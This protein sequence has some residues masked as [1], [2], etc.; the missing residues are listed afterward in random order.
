MPDPTPTPLR[1]AH[2]PNLAELLRRLGVSLVVTT[3]QAGKLVIVRADGDRVNTHFRTLPKPMGVAAD[4][5][6]LAVGTACEVREYQDHPAAA[7]EL[8]PQ[9]SHD[10]CYLPRVAHTTGDILVHEMTWA[11]GELWF[12]NTRFSCLCTRSDRHSFTPRWKPS[13]VSAL[14]PEDRCHLNGVGVRDDRVRYATAL[15]ETDAPAGWRANKR[16]GGVLIDV[17]RDEILL[18]GLSMPHSPR[19]R[20]GRL[21]LLESGRGGIGFVNDAGRYEPVASLPGFTR[22]LDFCGPLAFVGLSQ[23]RET[24][25]FGG[26][27]VAEL[28]ARERVCGVWVLDT[29]TGRTVALLKFE[30]GVQEVFAV[31]VLTGRRFPELLPAESDVAARSYSLPDPEKL[32][33]G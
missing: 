11:G 18:R 33:R 8:P 26:V 1:C 19:W 7:R 24:A 20:D 9:G 27:P 31:Q 6:R 15:G 28:P 16:E 22:G 17:G 14:A 29:F 12:V 23:V 21:W 2:T 30:E 13:F 25:V 4:G 5:D 3:Y 32:P 10:A